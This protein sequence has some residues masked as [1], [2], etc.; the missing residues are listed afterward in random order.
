MYPHLF[1]LPNG[2]ILLS[3]TFEGA[4]KAQVLDVN[5]QTW[6]TVDETAVQGGSAAM[7]LPGKI[8]TS[9]LGTI[10][11]AGVTGIPSASTTFVLDMMQQFPAWRQTPSMAF[12]RDYHNLTILP[13]GNVLVTGGGQTSGATDVSTA[14]LTPEMWS[15][16]AETWV[17]MA[18]AQ[19]PRLYHSTALLLPDGRVLVSGGGRTN[20]VGGGTV[21]TDRLNAEI[22]SPPYLFKGVRPTITSAPST[23]QYGTG[24]FVQTPDGATISK[25]ALIGLGSVTHSFNTNQRYIPLSFSQVSGGLDIDAPI[26]ANLAPPGHYMLFILD[27]NGVPSIAKI[28]KVQ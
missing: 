15:P 2:K 24:F 21:A 14:V 12:K 23:A 18:N 1:V 16:V 26:D 19:I 28:L 3:S 8:I 22:Y 27:G 6:T 13:D 9:G 17:P 20:G 7:Y 25:V 5:A 11:G 10:G 4:I